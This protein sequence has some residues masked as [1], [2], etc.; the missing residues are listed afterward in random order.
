MFQQGDLNG[1]KGSREGARG[2]WEMWLVEP[3]GLAASGREVRARALRRMALANAR[4][5]SRG[6]ER[7]SGEL[8]DPQEWRTGPKKEAGPT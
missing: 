1:V 3:A 4:T 6:R 7:G 2:K 5:L 8:V